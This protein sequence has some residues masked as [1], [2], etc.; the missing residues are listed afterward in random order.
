MLKTLTEYFN[1]FANT[2]FG[3][4]ECSP[5]ELPGH[6]RTCRGSRGLN[7]A[8]NGRSSGALGTGVQHPR[9]G[10][11]GALLDPAAALGCWVQ[12]AETPKPPGGFCTPQAAGNHSSLC[13]AAQG[14]VCVCAQQPLLGAVLAQL[15]CPGASCAQSQEN[16]THLLPKP[17]CH[18]GLGS[19]TGSVPTEQLGTAQSGPVTGA[20]PAEPLLRNRKAATGS[21]C[22]QSISATASS[23]CLPDTAWDH[24]FHSSP[25]PERK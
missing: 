7:L 25:L 6:G 22:S 10:G 9:A 19:A 20:V 3:C 14:G 11:A 2:G 4:L 1:T 13:L 18:G 21:T 12:V 24:T 23:S 17:H 16:P 8:G 5:E 15:C